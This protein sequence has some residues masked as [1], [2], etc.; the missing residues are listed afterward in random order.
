[1]TTKRNRATKP[2]RQLLKAPRVQYPSVL[3]LLRRW[4][5]FCE[6]SLGRDAGWIELPRWQQ[7]YKALC[8]SDRNHG[9]V[10]GTIDALKRI[11]REWEAGR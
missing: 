11:Q 9:H 1:M 6:L 7:R 10:L 2:I 5:E 3:S 4:G 8:R